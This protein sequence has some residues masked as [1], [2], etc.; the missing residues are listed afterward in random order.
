MRYQ[1]ALRPD[2]LNLGSPPEQ[3]QDILQFFSNSKQDLLAVFLCRRGAGELFPGPRDRVTPFI[4]KLFDAKH[5]LDV[6]PF[7]DPVPRFRLFRSKI[8]KLGFPESEDKRLNIDDLADLAYT[9][10][11]LVWNVGCPHK[12]EGEN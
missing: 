2:S 12:R 4:K 10:E 1:A 7:I 8:G 6:F 11:E 9:K 3:S 5:F